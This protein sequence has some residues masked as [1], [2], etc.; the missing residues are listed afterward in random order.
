MVSAPWNDDKRKKKHIWKTHNSISTL[1]GAE[2]DRFS[3]WESSCIENGKRNAEKHGKKRHK[4]SIVSNIERIKGKYA[5]ICCCM[6]EFYG[7]FWITHTFNLLKID[8][9]IMSDLP[10]LF[11]SNVLGFNS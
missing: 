2:N 4:I 11:I 9:V 6:V 8:E 10:I 3:C 7:N 1:E 5:I